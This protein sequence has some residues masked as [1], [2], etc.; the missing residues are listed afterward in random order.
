MGSLRIQNT[1]KK[2]LGKNGDNVGT[3]FGC[4]I[5]VWAVA[6]SEPNQACDRP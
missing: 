4:Q 2:S 3:P 1:L 5:V 6:A